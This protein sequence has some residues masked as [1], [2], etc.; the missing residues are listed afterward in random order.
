MCL[1]YWRFTVSYMQL[2][3]F[4]LCIVS[5]AS[6]LAHSQEAPNRNVHSYF[7][8]LP[9]L[10]PLYRIVLLRTSVATSDWW[11]SSLELSVWKALL[12]ILALYRWEEAFYGWGRASVRK[13]CHM[14]EANKSTRVRVGGSFENRGF[15]SME[16]IKWSVVLLINDM[17]VIKV[18]HAVPL[19]CSGLSQDC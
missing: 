17:F 9:S 16:M 6:I 14:W 7:D 8:F 15:M 3:A 1:K 13:A 12:K 10:F 11:D 19:R 18:Q 4:F 5:L 2:V